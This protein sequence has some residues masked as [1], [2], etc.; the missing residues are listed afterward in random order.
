MNDKV[1][2]CTSYIDG[3]KERYQNWIDYYTEYFTDVDLWMINDGPVQQTLDLK[4]VQL[5]TFEERL[6]RETVW[7]FPGWKRSFFSA[8]RW[9]IPRYRYIA[10]IESD[11][12]I[13]NSGKQDFF[14]YF[15]QEGYFTGYVPAYS[16][17]EAS[18]QIINKQSIRQYFL[19]KYSC[20][21][22]WYENIDF[23]CD[24]VRLNPTYILNG[25]RI[26]GHFEKIDRRFTFV[27][28]I[29]YKDFY[30]RFLSSNGS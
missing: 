14:Y 19:D 5:Q 28:G 6:G 7:I 3:D 30:G 29:S 16:F 21:E 20:R 9:L 1:V 2:F 15:N 18:L 26:E 11:C 23:E 24:L 27:S 8:L 13:T 22:N 17:P 12:W 25:D 4:G 10:H